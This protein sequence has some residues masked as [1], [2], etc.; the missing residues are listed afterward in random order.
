MG[1]S[2][3]KIESTGSYTDIIRGGQNWDRFAQHEDVCS[4]EVLCEPVDIYATSCKTGYLPE[5]YGE[6]HQNTDDLHCL[7]VCKYWAC[8]GITGRE[9][10][11]D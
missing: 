7:Y 5:R 3:R 10:R 2:V 6:D 11:C 9:G 1:L 4:T 8:S